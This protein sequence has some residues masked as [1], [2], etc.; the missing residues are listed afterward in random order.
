M[1]TRPKGEKSD[2]LRPEYDLGEMLK[3]GIQGKYAGRY[4]EGTN[5]VLLAPDVAKAFPT[6]QAVNE[7]LRLVLR[8]RRLPGA[9]K[10]TPARA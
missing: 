9:G 10:K 8:L 5:V 6:E 2:E 4:R 1:K 7:T 3:R